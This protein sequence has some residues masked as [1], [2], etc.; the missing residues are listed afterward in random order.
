MRVEVLVTKPKPNPF[1]LTEDELITKL[2][3]EIRRAGSLTT[4]A[5]RL[6]ISVSNLSDIV[7]HRRPP[8]PA[9]LKF[10]RLRRVVRYQ[11]VRGNAPTREEE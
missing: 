7:N 2:T 3:K 8:S 4:L 10:L 5:H 11:R 6:G 9:L 1:L